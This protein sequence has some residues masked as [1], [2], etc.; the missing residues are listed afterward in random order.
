MLNRQKVQDFRVDFE[1]AVTQLEKDYGVTISLGTIRFDS[2]ELRAKM[3]ARVGEATPKA[4]REDFQVGDTVKI[5]HKK[6]DPKAQFRIEKIMSKNIKVM[7]LDGSKS[8]IKVS[9]GLLVK[10]S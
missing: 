7:A 3:T 4:S 1:K 9:P 6:V 8:M 2:N 10:I 5:N